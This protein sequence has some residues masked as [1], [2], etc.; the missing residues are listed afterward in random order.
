MRRRASPELSM[1]KKSLEQGSDGITR[2][3]LFVT[4]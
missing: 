4:S 3:T 1:R 2:R